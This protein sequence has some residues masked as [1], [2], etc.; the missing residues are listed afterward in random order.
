M[1]RLFKFSRRQQPLFS[2]VTDINSGAEESGQG[3]ERGPAKPAPTPV[4]PLPSTISHETAK[5]RPKTA[6]PVLDGG[7]LQNF[8]GM[9][10][11]YIPPGS[12]LMGSPED[13]PE[14]NDDELQHRVTLTKGF[15][16]QTT[17]VTQRQ[18]K[19]VMKDNP[20]CF[21]NERNDYPV[22]G[23]SWNDCQELIRTLNAADGS[24]V[25]RL[26]TEAEWEYACRAGAQ[27]AFANGDISE[28]PCDADS[29]L[30]H[31]AWYR[32]NSDGRSHQV[33]TKAPNAWGLYDMHGN[34]CEW[35]QDRYGEYSA[36]PAIDPAGSNE[37]DLR[38]GR[39]GSWFSSAESCRSARRF[40]WPSDFRNDFI[41]F[42]LVAEPGKGSS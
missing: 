21:K 20:S 16:M 11:L 1:R 15:Y 33:A 42:R 37:G 29:C 27:S 31:M 26:P 17:L 10:F 25:Y 23:I 4:E 14:R 8:L 28:A 9:S 18:W 34:L 22:E 30:G 41:G 3:P 19:A 5:N 24:C 12:F 38:V 36:F 39:G 6:E 35:C 13:E 40:S 32:A 2:A 7:T